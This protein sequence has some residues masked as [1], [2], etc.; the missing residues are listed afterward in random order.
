[1]AEFKFDEAGVS[2]LF[3]S[4]GEKIKAAVKPIARDNQGKPVEQVKPLLDEALSAAGFSDV[5]STPI[6]QQI[7]NREHVQIEL[8]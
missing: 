8:R 7:S 4:I 5:D 2:K 6:A 1:M 3:D